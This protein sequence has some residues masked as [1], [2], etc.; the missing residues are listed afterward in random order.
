MSGRSSRLVIRSLL[1]AA[2]FVVIGAAAEESAAPTPQV[3]T[4][5]AL[6][7]YTPLGTDALQAAWVLGT[8]A[9]PDPYLLRVQL[10]EGAR[11]PAHR[12]PDGRITTVLH[13][14]LYVGFGAQAD[15]NRLVAVPE[16]GV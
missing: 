10:A 2:G 15:D 3:I 1:L 13:G 6:R 8:E 11:I 9:A 14:T 12:H 7:W 16:G 4:P 5:D